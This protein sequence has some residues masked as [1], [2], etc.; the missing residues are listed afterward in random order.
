M[1]SSEE[2]I[3]STPSSKKI[4]CHNKPNVE[5]NDELGTVE[6]IDACAHLEEELNVDLFTSD[7]ESKNFLDSPMGLSNDD[8]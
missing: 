5:T 6:D 2:A 8:F 3:K 7:E 1:K 4:V